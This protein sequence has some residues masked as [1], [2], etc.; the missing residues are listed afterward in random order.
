MEKI[1][2]LKAENEKQAVQ[3]NEVKQIVNNALS[4]D[5]S[6]TILH[7]IKI[8]LNNDNYRT[9]KPETGIPAK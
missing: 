3:L 2:Q 8:A 9:T 7:K 6:F 4:I 5:K 1:R